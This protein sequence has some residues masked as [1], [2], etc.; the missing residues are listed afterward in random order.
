MYQSNR[1]WLNVGGLEVCP[2]DQM[3]DGAFVA[4][5]EPGQL[6]AGARFLDLILDTG[7]ICRSWAGF[8]YRVNR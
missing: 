1:T 8:I 5:I 7:V 6:P 3:L 4:R 2:G